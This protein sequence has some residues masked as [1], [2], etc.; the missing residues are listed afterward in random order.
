MVSGANMQVIFS[1]FDDIV[2]SWRTP[3][4]QFVEKIHKDSADAA[5]CAKSM[6]QVQLGLLFCDECE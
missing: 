5:V 2:E 3:T 6:N 4:H 1:L